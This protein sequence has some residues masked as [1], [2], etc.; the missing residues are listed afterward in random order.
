MSQLIVII[1]NKYIANWLISLGNNCLPLKLI[2]ECKF[3]I[4]SELLDAEYLNEH[5]EEAA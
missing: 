3:L 2:D 5:L 4:A 1:N